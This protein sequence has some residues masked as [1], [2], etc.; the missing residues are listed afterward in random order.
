MN[1]KKM[2]EDYAKSN[3][4]TDLVHFTD[5]SD[6]SG[7][8]LMHRDGKEML[9]RLRPSIGAVITKTRSRVGRDYLGGVYLHGGILSGKRCPFRCYL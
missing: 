3:G 1:Q 7:R 2:L 9:G 8:I 6:Y 4:Y 5:D